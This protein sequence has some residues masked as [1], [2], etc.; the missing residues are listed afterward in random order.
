LW[1]WIFVQ[2]SGTISGRV[3][4]YPNKI[5]LPAI[6]SSDGTAAVVAEETAFGTG[7]GADADAGELA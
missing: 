1:V 7:G 6:P 3:L 5:R 2:V 4:L